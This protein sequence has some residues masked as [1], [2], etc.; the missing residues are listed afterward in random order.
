MRSD[1]GRSPESVVDD[2]AL[3]KLIAGVQQLCGD[4]RGVVERWR[5]AAHLL[6]VNENVFSMGPDN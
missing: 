4:D 2:G 5:F 6:T 3:V 1:E